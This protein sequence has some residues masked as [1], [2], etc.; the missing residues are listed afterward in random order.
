MAYLNEMRSDGA[1]KASDN[2]FALSDLIT[3]VIM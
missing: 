2:R 3:S 1:G